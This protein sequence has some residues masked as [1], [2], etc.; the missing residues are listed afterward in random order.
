APLSGFAHADSVAVEEIRVR[1]T[2]G[3]M[4]QSWIIKPANPTGRLPVLFTIHG[5]PIGAFGDGWHWR[6]NALTWANA[7]YM[8]VLPNARGSTVVGPV[9]VQGLW[10]TTGAA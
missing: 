3:A 4:V 6:W 9:F 2:D 1:S 5:G 7:G 10:L 8:V